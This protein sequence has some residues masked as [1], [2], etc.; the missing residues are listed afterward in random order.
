MDIFKILRKLNEAMERPTINEAI[1]RDLAKVYKDNRLVHK[2]GDNYSSSRGYGD[3]NNR[4][5]F[6]FQNTDYK[7]ITPEEAI[8]LKKKRWLIR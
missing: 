3:I 5:Q 7:E 2:I 6:D 1:P 8:N 4:A